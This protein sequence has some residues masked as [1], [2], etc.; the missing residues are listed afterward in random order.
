MIAFCAI[1]TGVLEIITAIRLRREIDSKWPMALSR[2]GSILFGL[3]L[4]L[5]PGPGAVTVV[6]LFVS[7]AIVFGALLLALTFLLR[8]RGRTLAS[9]TRGTV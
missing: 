5:F 2:I 7:Y 4:L 3:L 9:D 1:V 6:W 8:N